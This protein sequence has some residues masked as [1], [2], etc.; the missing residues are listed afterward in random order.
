MKALYEY[1]PLKLIISK[2]SG[3]ASAPLFITVP[4]N[5]VGGTVQGF[6]QCA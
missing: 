4:N 5:Q 2:D 3:N 6:C 1:D